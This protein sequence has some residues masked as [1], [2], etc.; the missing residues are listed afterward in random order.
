MTRAARA[1]LALLLAAAAGAEAGPA[2]VA[3]DYLGRIGIVPVRAATRLVPEGEGIWRF[4]SVVRTRG[5]AG[6][7]KG[8]VAETARIATAGDALRPLSYAKRDGLS[9][10]DRDIELRFEE[11]AVLA[12]YR[13]ET[14]RLAA[15]GPVH[16]LLSLRLVLQRDLAAGGLAD[17]Y[18]VVD[19]RG[20][21]RRIEVRHTG[22]GT[23]ATGLGELAAARLEY[24][25]GSDRRYVLWFA[26]ALD[27][28]LV[29]LEQHRGG[30]LR[31]WLVL[32]ARGAVGAQPPPRAGP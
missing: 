1:A 18:D 23:V 4:E 16:D 28:A 3:E 21:L 30:R 5:W 10:R 19:G 26:P 31:G 13:G 32:E 22:S 8:A 20:E 25:T 27:H 9:D 17:A 7:K 2:P 24:V 11:G 14:R 12:T 6:W 29:R 15:A